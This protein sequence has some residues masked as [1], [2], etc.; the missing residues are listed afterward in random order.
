M[1]K[2]GSDSEQVELIK[3]QIGEEF[4]NKNE[5][6]EEFSENGDSDSEFTDNGNLEDFNDNNETWNPMNQVS[7]MKHYLNQND[8]F[9]SIDDETSEDFEDEKAC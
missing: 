9:D 4:D 7:P 8:E 1:K 6:D 2:K 5:L 3:E